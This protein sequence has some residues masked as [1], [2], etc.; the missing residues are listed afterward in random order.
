MSSRAERRALQD[1]QRSAKLLARLTEAACEIVLVRHGETQWNV[2][3]R[4][5]GQLM[6][7]PGL[8]ERGRQQ[9]AVMAAR[10]QHMRFDS[11]YSSDLL[12]AT[13]TAEIVA[14]ALA[15]S[16]SGSACAAAAVDSAGALAGA[17]V[18]LEPRLRERH[19]GVLQGLTRAQAA[20]QQ[21]EAYRALAESVG[22]CIAGGLESLEQLEARAEQAL[23]ELAARHPG[24]RLLVV[25]HGGFLS[26]A[27]RRATG[28]HLCG[29]NVN[30][31]INT[32]RIDA[33]GLGR[34]G[35][36]PAGAAA[37]E[38]ALA[39]TAQEQPQDCQR[40]AGQ[41]ALGDG[42]ARGHSCRQRRQATWAVVQWGEADHLQGVGA[43]ASAFGGSTAG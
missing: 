22:P 27:Y 1:K 7:G 17:A 21:P 8:T 25:T 32:I 10:L 4:L 26:A 36:R 20:E 35:G 42:P 33:A 29:R 6:P 9:A 34:G 41:A 15:R 40:Q 18:R 5:Q 16:P 31:A 24:Q 2:E 13:E 11:L 39:A 30:A 12:R 43:L 3:Q 14:A 38:Q 37:A 28:Q 19:L 23:E